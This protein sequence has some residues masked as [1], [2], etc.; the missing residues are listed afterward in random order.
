MQLL[1]LEE[2]LSLIP[3]HEDI[4]H[5]VICDR[6]MFVVNGF[7]INNGLGDG[8]FK[9]IE[10]ICSN[11]SKYYTRKQIYERMPIFYHP[12]P[13]EIVKIKEYDCGDEYLTFNNVE[14]VQIFTGSTPKIYVI[15]I[16]E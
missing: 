14:E 10:R 9:V 13:G 15:K 6:G 16:K 8:E 1:S 11:K 12:E 5:F 3:D 7:E 2:Q 4:Y